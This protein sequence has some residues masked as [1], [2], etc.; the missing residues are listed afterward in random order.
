MRRRP[1]RPAR[2]LKLNGKLTLKPTLKLKPKTTA[3]A[4]HVCRLRGCGCGTRF[5][6]KG[7]LAAHV[8][9]DSERARAVLFQVDKWTSVADAEQ[10][11]FDAVHP[12]GSPGG[13]GALG[14]RAE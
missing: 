5:P 11:I 4:D 12:E 9:A 13:E 7:A 1:R 10:Y 3:K 8:R 14:L 2:R 6:S